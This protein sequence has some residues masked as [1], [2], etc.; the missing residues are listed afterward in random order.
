MEQ[1]LTSLRRDFLTKDALISEQT[2]KIKE[3]EIGQM[4]SKKL[5][6]VK[7]EILESMQTEFDSMKL[8]NKSKKKSAFDDEQISDLMDKQDDILNKFGALQKHYKENKALFHQIEEG[9]DGI[10]E[11][12][13]RYYSQ[14]NKKMADYFSKMN[15]SINNIEVNVEQKSVDNV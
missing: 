12:N 1:E 5:E 10:K 9:M 4:Q 13:E 7:N 6:I 15:A 3:L 2:L 11:N 14:T 8:A